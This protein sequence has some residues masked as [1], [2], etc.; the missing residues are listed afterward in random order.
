MWTYPS[1]LY[2]DTRQD[3]IQQTWEYP[4]TSTP[5]YKLFYL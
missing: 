2:L 4:N 1:E 5:K 3:A